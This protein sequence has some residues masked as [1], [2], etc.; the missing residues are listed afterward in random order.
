MQGIVAFLVGCT[1]GVGLLLSGMTDPAKVL[2]FLDLAGDWDPSLAFVMGG[3]ILVGAFGF[4]WATRRST[5]LLGGYFYLPT[6]HDI[7]RR[8]VWGSAV[9]GVGWGLAGFCPG[10]AWVSMAQGHMQAIVFV[11]AMAIGMWV[12]PLLVRLLGQI[13][14][15][16]PAK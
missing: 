9:F 8:L 5:T 10:P 15:V 3:A 16:R 13:F 1:F 6:L 4:A 7:D 12:A 11:L 14:G 2:G